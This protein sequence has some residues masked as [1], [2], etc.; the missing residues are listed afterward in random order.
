M[1][2]VRSSSNAGQGGMGTRIR[3]TLLVSS[4]VLFGTA[5]FLAPACRPGAEHPSGQALYQRYCASCHGLDG[6][7]NG[8]VATTMKAHPTDLTTLA[9][10]AGGRFDERD[11]IAIIDG[12]RDVTAHGSRDMPVWGVIF[13]QE[14]E[15]Q[16][17]RKYTVLLRAKVLADYLRSLQV[18]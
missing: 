4:L 13:D 11:V 10:R 9:R 5:P 1:M 7:G 2:H 12:R 8:P 6:K 15:E 16:P 14:L 18:K 3:R 17:Y